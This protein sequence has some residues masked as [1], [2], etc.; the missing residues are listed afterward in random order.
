MRQWSIERWVAVMVAIV[1]VC[2]LAVNV[3]QLSSARSQ[4]RIL[5]QPHFQISFFWDKT[6]AGWVTF[7]T[8]LGPARIRGFKILL[9]GHPLPY[10][11]TYL[12]ISNALGLG[13][14]GAAL[15]FT[16]MRAGILI[17]PDSSNHL[18]W[19]D[20][21]PAED[22]LLPSWKRI[23]FETCYCSIYDECWL[24]AKMV[25]QGGKDPRDDNCSTFQNEPHCQW[26]NG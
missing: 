15:D 4:Q 11:D 5:M 23:S 20:T 25:P 6:G 26:W 21:G 22:R 9:D 24:S 18:L 1:A 2:S 17:K 10:G 19:A 3:S 14:A 8:G 7:N 16:N 13:I 12:V